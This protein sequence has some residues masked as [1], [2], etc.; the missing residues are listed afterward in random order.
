[1]MGI[2]DMIYIREREEEGG[3]ELLHGEN[4]LLKTTEIS[5][6]VVL[7]YA[8]RNRPIGKYLLLYT[9]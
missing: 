6:L 5:R 3:Q 9:V 2:D 7:F 8:F 4:H 1:M